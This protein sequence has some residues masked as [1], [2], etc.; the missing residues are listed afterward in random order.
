MVLPVTKSPGWKGGSTRAPSHRWSLLLLGLVSVLVVMVMNT[1][2]PYSDSEYSVEAYAADVVDS[3]SAGVTDISETVTV[4]S[5]TVSSLTRCD[6]TKAG[7]GDYDD[8]DQIEDGVDKENTKESTNKSGFVS[9]STTSIQE[10]ND[11]EVHKTATVM[12]MATGYNLET[13]QRFVGSL[14]KTGYE[15]NIILVVSPDIGN[16]SSDYLNSKN[17][18]MHRVTYVKC[19]HPVNADIAA[20]DPSEIKNSHT[21]EL[22][23]CVEPYP[24][25]KHRWARFPLLGDL[26][27]KCGG[28]ENPETTCGGPVL[29]TDVRDTFFQRNPFGPEAPRVV[30]LQL[31]AEHYTI[32]TTHWLVDWPVGDCKGVHYD[33]P[34]ICSGTT[35][36]TRQAMLDYIEIF[37][38]EMKTWMAD[39]KCCCFETNGDDQSMHNYLYYSGMLEGVTGGVLVAKNRDALV[40]TVG[41]HGSMI[42]NTHKEVKDELLKAKGKPEPR[43]AHHVPYDLNYHENNGGKNWLGL[44]YG[45]TDKEG[46]FVDFDG[47]RSF[48]VHQYDR[49]GPQFEVFMRREKGQ[50]FL[51]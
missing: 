25:L 19:S 2:D 32:R 13:Y 27:R 23:T 22:V 35:I 45:L 39:E 17:V 37:H 50:I 11:E 49:L 33:E 10:Y 4:I 5:E 15:G 40:H 28:Q 18:V 36:G 12:G 46:Y 41:A 31:F 9:T 38:Q 30:G 21:K 6:P 24:E 51:P 43:N 34:M 3:V 29:V 8:D 47:S 26:L 42:F 1:N 14:R 48:I 44:H 20:K 16:E 7:G